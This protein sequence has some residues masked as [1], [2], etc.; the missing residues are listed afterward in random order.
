MNSK[1]LIQLIKHKFYT[2]LIFLLIASG[3]YF[4]YGS[5]F[6]SKESARYTLAQVQEGTLIVS[7][8]GS[9]QVSASDQVDI[10]PKASGEVIYLGVRNGQWVGVGE[11]VARLD[12]KD[13]EKSVRNA[14][15]SLEKAK[16]DFQKIKGV[17]TSG[18]TRIKQKAEDDLKKSYEDGFNLVANVFLDLPDIM[19]GLDDLLF[20]S[21][22]TA[23]QWNINYYADSINIY[24]DS[25]DKFKDDAYGKYQTARKEYEKNFADYKSSSRLSDPDII[26][27]LIKETYN[28]VRSAAEASK[29]ANNLIRLYKDEFIEHNLKPLSLADTHLASL[30]SYTGKTNSYLL[31][32]LNAKTGIKNA[33]DG[34]LD[35]ELDF[36]SQELSIKERE[37]S[38]QD[39][40]EKLKDY[41]IRAQFG[42]LISKVG[43]KI[44]D[45][46][47]ANT[48]IAT[49]VTRQKIAEITLN[50]VDITKVK[51]GQKATLTFDAISG[52]AL[53]GQVIEIDP[54]GVVSQGVV[55]YAV[56][57]GFDTQD[58]RVKTAMSV[59]AS[60]VTEAKQDVLLIPNSAVKQQR[61]ESFVEIPQ[62]PGLNIET[63]AALAGVTLENSPIQQQIEVGISNDEFTEVISGIKD[64][65]WVVSRTIQPNS[66]SPRPQSQQQNSFRVPGLTGG[67]GGGGFRR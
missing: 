7:V 14:E 38:L 23:S 1:L 31:S 20:S 62:E 16:L 13:V 29:S 44:G 4:G 37:N 67:G 26:D 2:G 53:T 17:N 33:K 63:G 6:G 48:S 8:S 19:T 3:I 61:E 59:S 27:K 42:G 47:S 32:L 54:L 52:L 34:I 55:T 18:T 60:I 45:S 66:S 50:E 39:S 30:N 15:I 28:A 36:K 65:D 51:V 40:K 12:S 49:L 9:G 43:I 5:I 25:A 41:S 56:K 10:K 57:I 46:V 35:A 24:N 64:G 22:I 58:D 11:A 21:V